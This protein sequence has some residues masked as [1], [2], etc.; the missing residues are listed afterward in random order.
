MEITLT[1]ADMAEANQAKY[2][3]IPFGQNGDQTTTGGKWSK[4]VKTAK[5]GGASLEDSVGITYSCKLKLEFTDNYDASEHTED[6]VKNMIEQLSGHTGDAALVLKGTNVGGASTDEKSID[7]SSLGTQE[8]LEVNF[9]LTG[10]SDNED[11]TAEL[12]V[13]NTGAPQNY[14]AN[15][16]LDLTITSTLNCSEKKE[17]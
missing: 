10:A 12:Y 13:E 4:S 15:T 1:T 5:I 16:S 6:N 11:Y 14:L 8:D 2:Y 17:G 9:E 3:A 7:V